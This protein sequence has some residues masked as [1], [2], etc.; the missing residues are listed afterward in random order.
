MAEFKA[1]NQALFVR[2]SPGRRTSAFAFDLRMSAERAEQIRSAAIAA[3]LIAGAFNHYTLEVAGLHVKAEHV[4]VPLLL[5][6]LVWSARRTG[7][8]AALKAFWWLAPFIL[9]M[10]L[11]SALN[12][13]D[14]QAS[15]R[16]T[17]MVTVVVSAAPVIYW[18]V[19]T[20]QR[21][22]WAVRLLMALGVLEAA[23]AF[24]GLVAWWFGSDFATQRGLGGIRVPYGSL[25]EANFLGS[26]LAASAMLLLSNLLAGVS[27]RE[28]YVLAGA[29]AFVLSAL[30]LSLA[31]ISWAATMG[32]GIL[33]VAAYRQLQRRQPT[34]L[35]SW[36]RGARMA[37]VALAAALLFLLVI[38]PALFP[39]TARS[40]AARVNPS[41]FDPGRDP[42][43][44]IRINLAAQALDGVMAHPLIGNGTGS[45]GLGHT[46]ATG[47][48]G[49]ISNLELHLLYDGGIIGL[50]SVLGGLVVLMWRAGRAL[51][52]QSEA[53][54]RPEI[55]GL[56]AA[57]MVILL[58]YQSTEGSWLAFTWVYVGLLARA[59]EEA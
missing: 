13:P 3:L 15:L 51:Y 11:S 14:R 26:F 35:P 23:L 25:W 33:V 50:T 21:L 39:D 18:L 54:R 24:A 40:I 52:T 42:S 37:G 56:L 17:L 9:A 32:I 10:L 22:R 12:S 55:I 27:K 46:S 38:A 41:Y 58:T 30:G 16:Y 44:T 4:I 8:F 53:A 43:L 20:T 7:Q 31:R 19:N 48:S 29:L 45:F 59:S 28:R 5:I 1:P 49:W 36:G 2:S 57:L 34:T 47:E 6:A